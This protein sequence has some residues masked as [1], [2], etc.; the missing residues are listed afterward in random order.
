M[1]EESPHIESASDDRRL[2]DHADPCAVDIGG[3][4]SWTT[5]RLVF[6]GATLAEVVHEFS[7]YDSRRL[8]TS[9]LAAIHGGRLTTATF[10]APEKERPVATSRKH[11]NGDSG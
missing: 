5:G 10:S 7:N 4:F 3:Q 11:I 2:H 6:H 9:D 1:R 8:V